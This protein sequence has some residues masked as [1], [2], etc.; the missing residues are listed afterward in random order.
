ME[1]ARVARQLRDDIVLGRRRP[2]SRLVERD[3]AAQL[4]VSRLPVREAIRALVTEGIVVARPRTWAV[5][6]E[7]TLGDVRDF[8]EVRGPIETMLFVYAAERH[9]E[10]GLEGL[11]RVLEREEQAA[12]D[13]DQAASRAAAG[14]FHAYMA[15]LAS[16][17][18]L[19]ELAGV[20]A[21][22]LK[23]IFGLHQDLQG[24]AA[25][26]RELFEAIEARDVELVR[27]LLAEHLAAGTAAAERRFGTE[28]T[29]TG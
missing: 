8:A 3:I 14:D 17:D 25:S 24:M 11:R 13:G 9:D 5:V 29:S 18:V 21:T 4:N 15:V 16:N 1:S 28:S 10:A 19:T 22:R 20:F 23:W 6:R 7:Y 2:G 27:R 26:H 12:R